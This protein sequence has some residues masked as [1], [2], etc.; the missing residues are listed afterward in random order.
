M[1]ID[2]QKIQC[3]KCGTSISIDDV[4]T[5]QIEEKIK[6]DFEEKQKIREQEYKQRDKELKKHDQ[7]TDISKHAEVGIYSVAHRLC[8]GFHFFRPRAGQFDRLVHYANR[9]GHHALGAV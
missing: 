5:H 3:P 1:A 2:N 9:C 7:K 8:A 6:N 4:L